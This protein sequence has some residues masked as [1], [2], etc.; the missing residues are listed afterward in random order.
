MSRTR[1]QQGRWASQ[2]GF[3]PLF[4]LA[5]PLDILRID[6]KRGHAVLLGMD[7]TLGIDAFLAGEGGAL[8]VGFDTSRAKVCQDRNNACDTVCP[9]R[10]KPR[11]VKRRMFNC[12]ESAQCISAC[13]LVQRGDPAAGLLRWVEGRDALPV[14]TRPPAGETVVRATVAAAA[15]ATGHGPSPLAS[16]V[17][18][19]C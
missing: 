6:L 18:E 1:L 14:I 4:V 15:P 17:G 3:F 12:T 11:T 2:V 8:V 7:W 13:A 5:P 9:M 19:G 16:P 10:L